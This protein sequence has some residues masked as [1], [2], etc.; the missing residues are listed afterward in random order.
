MQYVARDEL[1]VVT[2]PEFLEVT[3]SHSR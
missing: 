1:T 3:T 2:V